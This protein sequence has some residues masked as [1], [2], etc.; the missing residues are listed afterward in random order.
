MI[1]SCPHC[2]FERDIDPATIPPRAI[3]ARCPRCAERFPL[4]ASPSHRPQP[5]ESETQPAAEKQ[6]RIP[7]PAP[8]VPPKLPAGFGIRLTAQLIDFFVLGLL[9]LLLLA[10]L[11]LIGILYLGDNG[12]VA[13]LGMILALF[14]LASFWGLFNT[15]MVSYCGQ[16]PGKRVTRIRV[17][18][19]R[20]EE[21]GV[22]TAFLREVVAKPISALLLLTGFLMILFDQNHQGLHDR[23]AQTRVVK[24]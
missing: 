23:I 19:D 17:E 7:E 15:V 5:K 20:G 24:L 12:P 10:G 2:R 22:G 4:P 16:T 3:M 6:R 21:V 11:G 1:L 14:L 18:G 8:S 13:G 9:E